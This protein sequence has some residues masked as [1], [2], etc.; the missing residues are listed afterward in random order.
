MF[1]R[2]AN[3][4]DVLVRSELNPM[5]QGMFDRMAQRLGVTNGQITR[6]QFLSLS[7]QG[8]N[9]QPGGGATNADGTQD[10]SQAINT[11]AEN[12]FQ[13]FDRNRDGVLN[14]DEMP[15]EL[16]AELPKWDTNKDGVIDLNEFKAFF[17]ARVQQMMAERQAMR[18]QSFANGGLGNQWNGAAFPQT[19][20][21]AEPEEDPRPVVYRAGNLPPNLPPWFRQLDTD[22][23]GQ[24]GLYEWKNSGRPIEEFEKMDRN[25]DGFLTIDEVLYAESKNTN[26]G[27]GMQAGR[28]PGA[29]GSGGGAAT[30]GAAPAGRWQGGPPNGGNGG[31]NRGGRN[32]NAGGGGGGGNRNWGGGGQSFPGG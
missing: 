10:N 27:R 16:K 5:M 11:W 25:G 8:G 32:R 22:Q 6:E 24:I 14:S 3:G 7:S 4:K 1:D 13:Q 15:E 18:A 29:P 30:P 23:D 20:T 28:W 31:G 2:L 19:P 26:Q 9:R 12:A 17:Q 21:P